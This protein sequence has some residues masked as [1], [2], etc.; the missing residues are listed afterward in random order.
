M[1]EGKLHMMWDLEAEERTAC[2]V[3]IFIGARCG[4]QGLDERVLNVCDRAAP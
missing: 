4:R 1:V 3:P 2:Y